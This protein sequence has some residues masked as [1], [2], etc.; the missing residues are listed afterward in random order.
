[1]HRI[2]VHRQIAMKRLEQWPFATVTRNID[3]K[4]RW[5][6]AIGDVNE[7]SLSPTDEEVIQ[8]FQDANHRFHQL[9]MMKR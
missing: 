5:I 2:R 4:A 7:L 3:C 6:Q 9:M 8:K 1:M